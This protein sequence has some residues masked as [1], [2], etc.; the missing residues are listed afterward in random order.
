MVLQSD[1]AHTRYKT[2][3]LEIK[4]LFDKNM[5]NKNRE[6]KEDEREYINL[7]CLW[8]KSD[9]EKSTNNYKIYRE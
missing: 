7:H 5:I 2:I 3:C 8:A 9:S 1:E 4:Y 6:I